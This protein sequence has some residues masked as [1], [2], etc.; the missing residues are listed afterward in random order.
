VF[1]IALKKSSSRITNRSSYVLFT[2]GFWPRVRART[3]RAPVFFSSLPHQTGR[4]APPVHRSFPAY[5]STPK[6]EQNLSNLC[7]P[8]PGLFSF[9][10]TTEA[11]KYEVS[12]PC[13]THRSFADPLGNI[14]G[15]K[16]TGATIRPNFFDFSFCNSILFLLSIL[17]SSYSSL[18]ILLFLPLL[19]LLIGTVL[20][21]H[22][23]IFLYFKLFVVL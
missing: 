17:I 4:C 6:N 15:S 2:S 21:L 12:C 18:F 22:I 5:Y 11:M 14:L 7:R 9:H 1:A 16:C 23:L 13:P 19:I 10:G 20:C 3:L 8:H